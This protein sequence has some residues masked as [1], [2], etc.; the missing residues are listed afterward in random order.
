MGERAA[1]SEEASFF[2]YCI[3]GAWPG[4]GDFFLQTLNILP[5]PYGLPDVPWLLTGSGHCEATVSAVVAALRGLAGSSLQ[6][7]NMVVM[8]PGPP[9]R[10]RCEPVTFAQRKALFFS[11]SLYLAP[12]A[13]SPDM[14]ER[15]R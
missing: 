3:S 8:R 15:D 11:R 10:S 9:A 2:K 6:D 4:Q 7:S 12:A 5:P 14:S 1:W 13:Q